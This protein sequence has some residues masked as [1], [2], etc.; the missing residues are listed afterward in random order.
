MNLYAQI[1][2]AA[3]LLEFFLSLLSDILN[4]LHI[5]PDL[6]VEFADVW[7]EGKYRKS[8]EYLKTNTT[9]GIITSTFMLIITLLFWFLKGFNY[10][11]LYIRSFGLHPIWNGLIFVGTLIFFRTIISLPFSIYSTFVIEERFGFNKTTV[12]TFILDLIKGIALSVAIGA[13]VFAGILAFFQYAGDLAWLWCWITVTGFSLFI[14]F[15]AP[16]WI[17]PLFNKFTPLEQ[18]ELRDRIISFAEKVKFP[19]SNIFVMD[20]SKRSSKSNAFF[21]GFGKHRRIALYDTLIENHTTDQ[22]VAVLAHEI[23]H[24]K[25]RHILQHLV[26]SLLFSGILFWM[27]SLFL[28]RPG[29]YEAFGLAVDPAKGLPL[30]AGMV[31]FGFLYK[32]VS[33]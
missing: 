22:L 26:A 27:L 13:P 32:P 17:L 33:L 2:L 8:Q 7:D 1:I 29:L 31:F 9:F 24:Y 5:K 18:G 3:I 16:V 14:Q 28:T 10:L 4:I 12:K 15:I 23:G 19:L 25:L 11:D 20:G 6:P 30:Y 21:T